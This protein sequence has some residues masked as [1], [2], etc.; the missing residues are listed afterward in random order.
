MSIK[1]NSTKRLNKVMNITRRKMFL[2]CFDNE[3]FDYYAFI[4]SKISASQK[5][6]NYFFI[7]NSVFINCPSSFIGSDE[8]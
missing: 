6:N 8:H 4:L 1:A 2:L 5:A 7:Y 3:E